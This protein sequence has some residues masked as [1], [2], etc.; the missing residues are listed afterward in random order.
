MN[1]YNGTAWI[2]IAPT[3]ND[4]AHFTMTAGVPSWTG[5]TPPPPPVIG[6]FRDG[7]I[8]FWVDG[9]GGGLVCAIK[10]QSDGIQ[11]YNGNHITTGATGIDIGTG[12]AN[13]TAIIASQGAI[14]TAYAAGLAR[15]YDGGGYTD[16]FLPS[17]DELHQMRLNQG[18]I[19]ST[20]QANFGSNFITAAYYRSSSEADNSNAWVQY[21]S[22]GAR[23]FYSKENE[24]YRMRAVR[25]F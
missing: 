16:W 1:Y 8:V 17:K 9:N 18:T 24:H 19:N 14:E 12:S 11:W 2:T 7:G 4:G 22:N 10:D 5:G 23:G 21:F 25:A 20:A 3:A 6:D 15:A 13:T